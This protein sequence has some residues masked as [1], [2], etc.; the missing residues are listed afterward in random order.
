[1]STIDTDL[2]IP[3]LLRKALTFGESC[4]PLGSPHRAECQA[5]MRRI[6]RLVAGNKIVERQLKW[7]IVRILDEALEAVSEAGKSF[8]DAELRELIEEV[9]GIECQDDDPVGDAAYR[10]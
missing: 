6:P 2:G 5:A 9:Q 10:A 8:V 3:Q 7:A 1:M 4:F